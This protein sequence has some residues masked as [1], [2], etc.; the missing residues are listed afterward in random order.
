[1]ILFDQDFTVSLPL[2][3]VETMVI[4]RPSPGFIPKMAFDN[5]DYSPTEY[6]LYL[7][8]SV[9]ARGSK[10][11]LSLI[12]TE[13]RIIQN[14]LKLTKPTEKL[15]IARYCVVS[16]KSIRVLSKDQLDEEMNGAIKTTFKE[17][18]SSTDG[19]ISWWLT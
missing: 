4:T 15:H 8:E 19:D 11:S 13:L 6:I 16:S 3:N 1:M 14:Q 7:D 18:I 9:V 17:L 10:E 12:M 2:E 5:A